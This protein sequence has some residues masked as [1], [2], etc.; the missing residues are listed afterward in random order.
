MIQEVEGDLLASRC[1]AI[2]HGVAPDEH[3]DTG[4][5]LQLREAWPALAKDY[6]HWMHTHHAEPGRLWTWTTPDGRRIVNLITHGAVTHTS[7]SGRAQL[8]FVNQALRAL[9]AEITREEMP[10]LALPRFAT[11]SGGLPWPEVKALI[12][13]HLGDL[14]IPIYV[15]A[16]YKKGVTAAE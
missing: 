16:T 3:F 2:A 9:R 11:G 4:L 6:R 8:D 10:S 15:Y 1:R 7:H 12:D 13:H 14:Q 5:A